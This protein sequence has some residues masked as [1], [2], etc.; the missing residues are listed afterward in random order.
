MRLSIRPWR[1]LALALVVAGLSLGL[2]G[3]DRLPRYNR[4]SEFTL[5]QLTVEGDRQGNVSLAGVWHMTS[6]DLRLGSYSA[7]TARP[8]GRLMAYADS[9]WW[10]SFVPPG[11]GRPMEARF[12][13]NADPYYDPA[14]DI[15]SAAR[16]PATGFTWLGVE[17]TNQIRRYDARDQF[18]GRIAPPAMADFRV[19]GGAEAMTRLPDG[20]FLVLA[21]DSAW[22]TPLKRVGLM[23][24]RDPLKGDP[25]IEF[26]F[27]PPLGF[28]PTEM[29]ALP[30]GRVLILMRAIAPS[31]RGFFASRILIA[32]SR[33]IAAGK[34][35]PWREIVDV[36][37][38]APPENYEGMV[39]VPE[40]KHTTIWLISDANKSVRLQRTLLVKLIWKE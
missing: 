15:E 29:A 19:N 37:A 34:T 28:D 33:D 25:P 24:P 32:D 11:N 2:F 21:E 39:A 7:L 30:D 16:D 18:A 26:A 1:L 6:T 20:R 3:S 35:W 5:T 10:L 31:L 13:S 38:L 4:S 14:Y 40:G 36:N 9:A 17:G 27:R 8:G 12:G 22:R 23:F